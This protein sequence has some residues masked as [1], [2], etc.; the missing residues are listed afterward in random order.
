MKHEAETAGFAPASRIASSSTRLDRQAIK[1]DT[2]TKTT[3]GSGFQNKS[4][5]GRKKK[6][7]GLASGL[8][9][10]SLSAF[11][12]SL[13]QGGRHTDH[14][15]GHTYLTS[16]FRLQTTFMVLLDASA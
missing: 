2:S 15:V 3:S 12:K 13:T 5:C 11:N 16:G 10:Q 8:V 4:C 9:N 1:A 14:V 7:V 6:N